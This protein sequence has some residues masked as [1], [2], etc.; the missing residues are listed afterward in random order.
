[1]ENKIAI[2]TT[3]FFVDYIHSTFSKMQLDCD[4]ELFLYKTF[5]DIPELYQRIPADIT[6]VL[7]SGSF[8]ARVIQLA[9]PNTQRIIMPFNTDD[10]AIYQLF[11]RLL[12]ENRYL[13]FD[14]IYADV[15]EMFNIDLKTYLMNDFS[16]PVAFTTNRMVHEKGLDELFQIEDLEYQKHLK[17]W[18]SGTIDLCVTRFSSIVERLREQGVPVYFPYPS[19]SYLREI[20]LNLLRELEY[21]QLQDNASAVVHVELPGLLNKGA[22]IS[23]E[24]LL[25]T[26]QAACLEFMGEKSLDCFFRR[27]ASGLEILTNRKNIENI[28]DGYQVCRL[29]NLL[30]KYT[31]LSYCIGYG[32][33]RNLHQ[34]RENAKKAIRESEKKSMNFSYIIDENDTLIGPLSASDFEVSKASMPQLNKKT[35]AKMS[36]SDGKVKEVFSIIE[37]MSEQQITS[38]QLAEELNITKR[39]ANRILSS[40]EEQQLVEIVSARFTSA[41]GRPE[42]I[43]KAVNRE[44]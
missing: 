41:K 30:R 18:K 10:A 19:V 25:V 12:E 35:G 7:T 44:E 40:M 1:M 5:K 38:Q 13:D 26:M 28:T 8:P 43:Y 31:D 21:K 4:Y 33:G 29:R 24:Y 14:R 23:T 20:C 37:R 42:R 2:I 3:D 17:L 32:I 34:A 16:T 36:V 11:F 27:G 22:E 15:V 6:G 9:F 39:S